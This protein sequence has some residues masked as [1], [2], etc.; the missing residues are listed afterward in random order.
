MATQ[1]ELR[2]A[3]ER[4]RGKVENAMEAMQTTLLTKPVPT[5]SLRRKHTQTKG[6]W[7]EIQSLYDHLRIMTEENQAEL[8]RVMFTAFQ[9][10]YTEVHGHVEDILEKERSEE[11]A[12]DQARA[13]KKR[14]QQLQAGWKAIH[15]R[16]EEVLKNSTPA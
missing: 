11:E 3:L 9:N 7:A 1:A 8:D 13:S 4:H 5:L 2:A 6:I 16:I 14:E 10:C 12:H 15:H